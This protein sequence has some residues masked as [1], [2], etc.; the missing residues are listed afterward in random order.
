CGEREAAVAVWLN[1][2]WLDPHGAAQHLGDPA[3]ADAKLHRTWTV[4]C[5][6]D[7]FEE[8]TTGMFPAYCLFTNPRL[9]R[10]LPDDLAHRDRSDE[11]TFR[12]AR[13]LMAEDTISNRQALHQLAPWL[14]QLWLNWHVPT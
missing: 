14:L 12:A 6:L 11:Q 5:N 8:L 13:R 9:G 7:L 2:C 10:V 1:L 4:F 3:L